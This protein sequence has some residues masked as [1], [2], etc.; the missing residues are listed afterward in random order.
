MDSDTFQKSGIPGSGCS[1]HQENNYGMVMLSCTHYTGEDDVI[2][3]TFLEGIHTCHLEVLEMKE[4]A[5][6]DIGRRDRWT[7]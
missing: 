7:K 3:L 2:F 4:G 6:R 5:E 1:Y